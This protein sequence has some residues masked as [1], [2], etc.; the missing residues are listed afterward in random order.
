MLHLL[1]AGLVFIS[2]S[3]T[4]TTSSG[5]G[6]VGATGGGAIY[7]VTIRTTHDTQRS[8]VINYSAPRT[9]SGR[10]LEVKTVEKSDPH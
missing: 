10:A 9:Q 5:H 6:R 8:P 4:T 2:G 3:Q 7:H 1:V